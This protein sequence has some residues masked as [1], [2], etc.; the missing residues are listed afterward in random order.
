M[1][2]QKIDIIIGVVICA[3]VVIVIYKYVKDNVLNEHLD[4]IEFNDNEDNMNKLLNEQLEQQNKDNVIDNLTGENPQLNVDWKNKNNDN[5]YKSMS[6][7]DGERGEYSK[8]DAQDEYESQLAENVDYSKE[9]TNGNFIPSDNGNGNYA[10]YEQKKK[11]YTVDELMN[12]EDM[13]PQEEK[14][15]FDTVPE[16][17]KVKNRHLININRPIGIDTVGS[18]MKIACRDLRPNI[19]APKFV[20]SPFLN[21][22]VEPDVAN[23]GFCNKNPYN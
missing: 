7:L 13:L 8:L 3:V 1:D 23:V 20:V 2:K 11:D 9:N 4:E 22:S 12:V 19:P 18:S 14:D 21:S 6:Y 17:I 5:K 16:P 15:W 10:S